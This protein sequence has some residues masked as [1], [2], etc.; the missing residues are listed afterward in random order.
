MFLLVFIKND[1]IAAL[2]C[3]FFSFLLMVAEIIYRSGTN[4]L[5]LH[6]D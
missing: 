3:F 4:T 6:R 2:G 5:R 1:N